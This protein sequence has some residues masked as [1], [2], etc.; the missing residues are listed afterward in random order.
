M[1]LPR[2]VTNSVEVVWESIRGDQFTPVDRH[3]T[4]DQLF[5]LLKGQ[6]EVTIGDETSIVGPQTLVFIPRNT[7][8]NIKPITPEGLEYIYFIVWGQGVP[9]P[10][11]GW[12]RAYSLIH[13]RRTGE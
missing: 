6:G 7:D 5:F 10:E 9:E 8:H 4:F 1:L 2:D 3:P 12:K 11:R 13:E